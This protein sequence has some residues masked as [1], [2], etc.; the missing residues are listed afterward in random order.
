VV[1]RREKAPE[2]DGLPP[3][4]RRI[5]SPWDTD[6]RWGMKRDEAWPG[7]ELHVSEACDDAPPCDCGGTRASG[8][9]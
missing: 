8:H 6:A 7:Y 4:H 9:R 5:A 2:G 3:A 1:K